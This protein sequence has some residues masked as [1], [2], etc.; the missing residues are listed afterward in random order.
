MNRTV[1]WRPLLGLLAMP[2]LAT[3]LP[4]K[5]F[6]DTGFIGGGVM[7]FVI[8]L[9]MIFIPRLFKWGVVTM[10]LADILFLV[11]MF[12]RKE[13]MDYLATQSNYAAIIEDMSRDAARFI[14]VLIVITVVIALLACRGFLLAFLLPTPVRSQSGKRRRSVPHRDTTSSPS[15]VREPSRGKRPRIDRDQEP[16]FGPQSRHSLPSVSSSQYD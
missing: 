3:A 15:T 12:F 1:N 9:I 11:R 7:L 8:G 14:T 10:L 13:V 6:M 5:D 2:N 16:G 4:L